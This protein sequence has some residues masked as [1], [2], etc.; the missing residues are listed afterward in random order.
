MGRRIGEAIRSG[1]RGNPGGTRDG[2]SGPGPA[3]PEPAPSNA[4]GPRKASG[5]PIKETVDVR[6][7]GVTRRSRPGPR[8]RR[9]PYFIGEAEA[10]DNLDLARRTASRVLPG[11]EDLGYSLIYSAAA[12]LIRD[13]RK[14]TEGAVL[15]EA[16]RRGE[17]VRRA[18]RKEQ[19]DE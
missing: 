9:A 8:N 4:S 2:L 3:R 15:D 10:N 5:R 18:T 19:E 12:Y 13:G 17:L 16:R 7:G 6:A 1:H 11:N 14:L